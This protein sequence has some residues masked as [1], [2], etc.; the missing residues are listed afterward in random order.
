[1]R[2]PEHAR[3]EIEPFRVFLKRLQGTLGEQLLDRSLMVRQQLGRLETHRCSKEVQLPE[4]D[5]LHPA[6][7]IR[8]RRTRKAYPLANLLL[9]QPGVP[10]SRPELTAEPAVEIVHALSMTDA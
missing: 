6:L 5:V 1:M 7:D 9:G 2:F 8:D 4:A 3:S 10:P